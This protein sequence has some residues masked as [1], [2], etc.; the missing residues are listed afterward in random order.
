MKKTPLTGREITVLSAWF[1][2][3]NMGQERSKRKDVER[4][5]NIG[6]LTLDGAV[7]A[8]CGDLME[9][10]EHYEMFM[11]EARSW[12][13]DF[14]QGGEFSSREAVLKTWPDVEE[15]FWPKE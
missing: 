13:K 6:R 5:L 9:S 15:Y 2:R 8:L 14:G 10:D 12:M 4:L 11:T 1:A 7:T 3:S